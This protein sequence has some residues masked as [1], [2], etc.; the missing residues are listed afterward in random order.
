MIADGHF[1]EDLFY[2]LNVIPRR[3]SSSREA[4]RYSAAG[5]SLPEAIRQWVCGVQGISKDAMAALCEPGRAMCASSKTQSRGWWSGTDR[6]GRH[7]RPADRGAAAAGVSIRPKQERRRTVADDLT[8]SCVKIRV[9]SG[10]RSIRC[11][12]RGTKE[13][14]RAGE[15]DSRRRAAGTASSRSCSIWS[16]TTTSG[17]STSSASTTAGSVQGVPDSDAIGVHPWDRP[18][19]FGSR[20]RF[21]RSCGAPNFS[22]YRAFAAASVQQPVPRQAAAATPAAPCR[23]AR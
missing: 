7:R 13:R 18:P 23:L 21:L 3:P 6:R 12:Q 22:A 20:L 5:Q 15:R 1:R 4:R 17:F 8:A 19:A 16:P 10:P 11:M 2:R 14:A 9:R